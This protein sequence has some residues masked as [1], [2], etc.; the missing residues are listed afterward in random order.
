MNNK[1][2]A[3]TGIIYTLLILF[4]MILITV[5]AGLRASQKLM[6]N[7]TE[8]FETSFEGE[9]VDITNTKSTGIASHSGKYIFITT[10]PSGNQITC[11]T[12]LSKGTNITKGVIL[13]PKDCNDYDVSLDSL[14]EIYS[15]EKEN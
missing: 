8:I 2:F 7:S 9:S 1:G 6:I 5:L 14:S 13:S 3:I 10:S 4:L 15:F 12:Y 11:S